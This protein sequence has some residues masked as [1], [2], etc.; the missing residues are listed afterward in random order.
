MISKRRLVIGLSVA[1]GLG[2]VSSSTAPAFAQVGKAAGKAKGKEAAPPAPVEAPM[3]PKPIE[4]KPADL[5]WGIDKKKLEAVYDKSVDEEYRKKLQKVNPGPDMEA[6][7]AEIQAKK[8]EFRRSYVAFE[9]I[10][11]GYDSTPLRQEYGYQNGEALMVVEKT[12]SK[13]YYFLVGGRVYKV[14]DE[15]KLGEKSKQGKTFDE[16]LAN[17]TKN[18]GVEGR[19]READPSQGRNFL[20]IDWKDAKTELRAI[21]YDDAVIAYAY[22][23]PNIAASLPGQRKGKDLGADGKVGSDVAD[24]MRPKGAEPPADS[25]KDPKKDPKKGAPTPKK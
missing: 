25:K 7:E 8:D 5:A 14:I 17:Q 18:L 12:S 4:L 19:R 21:R 24:V 3:T 23:D 10:A 6:L 13:R 2:F 20:E 22:Q 16:A 1:L 9:S 15:Y 11:T